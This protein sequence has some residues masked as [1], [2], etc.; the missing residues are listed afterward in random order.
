MDWHNN[1][2]HGSL[3]LDRLEA[4]RRHSGEKYRLRR[5]LAL[6]NKLFGFV[7]KYEF[8]GS[9]GHSEAAKN[10]ETSA[11]TSTGLQESSNNSEI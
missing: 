7:I 11:T 4:Q 2:P 9:N 10:L 6:A 5:Y 3:D 8:N 1:R